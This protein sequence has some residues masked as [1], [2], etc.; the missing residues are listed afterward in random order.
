MND[1][2]YKWY[3]SSEV[4]IKKGDFVYNEASGSKGIV[5]RV[6]QGSILYTNQDGTGCSWGRNADMFVLKEEFQND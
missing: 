5:T 3:P 6:K 1:S 2:N 4:Y